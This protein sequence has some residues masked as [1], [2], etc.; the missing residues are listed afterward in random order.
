M[1]NGGQ[2]RRDRDFLRRELLWMGFKE[3]QKSVWIYPY[4]IEKELK[5]LLEF[6][7]ADFAGDIRFLT[8]E[9]MDDKDLREYFN[10]A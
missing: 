7:K 9:N 6:W 2:S 3:L 4:E 5:A 1:E 10:L 8:I